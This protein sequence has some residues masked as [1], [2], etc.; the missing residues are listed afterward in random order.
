MKI[1]WRWWPGMSTQMVSFN[2]LNTLA[3]RTKFA[4]VIWAYLETT[5]D[6]N[7][8]ILSKNDST[9]ILGTNACQCSGV[10]AMIGLFTCVYNHI[11]TDVI[12]PHK[13]FGPN[14][15]NKSTVDLFPKSWR[16]INED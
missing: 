7:K 14:N 15:A 10:L 12:Y 11:F 16:I 9:N 5:D 2:L 1:L 13:W 4:P 8:Y 3:Y 6:I